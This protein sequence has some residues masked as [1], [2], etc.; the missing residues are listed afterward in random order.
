MASKLY[1]T[2]IPTLSTK[3]WRFQENRHNVDAGNI[4]RKQGDSNQNRKVGISV[5]I[6]LTPPQN[7]TMEEFTNC[8][9]V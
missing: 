1:V 4:C 6:K 7:D 5:N 8:L 2:E 9:A 3:K